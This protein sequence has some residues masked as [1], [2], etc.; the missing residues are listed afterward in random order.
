MSEKSPFNGGKENN[1]IEDLELWKQK[2]YYQRLG[3]SSGATD[4]EIKKAFRK[5]SI[6][7]HPDR[8]G[9][10]EALVKNYEEIYKLI[11]DARDKLTGK[12]VRQPARDSEGGDIYY[13]DFSHHNQNFDQKPEFRKE[14]YTTNFTKEIIEDLKSKP[15]EY[16]LKN[17]KESML[18]SSSLYEITPGE[19]LALFETLL[20]EGFV[21]TTMK[22]IST[23]SIDVA[24][25][26]ANEQILEMSQM[27]IDRQKLFQ[28]VSN[29]KN[30][31]GQQLNISS[32]ANKEE[33]I[34]YFVKSVNTFLDSKENSG[35]LFNYVTLLRDLNMTIE[36]LGKRGVTRPELLQAI[37][38]ILLGKFIDTVKG[39]FEYS[40]VN[41]G[42]REIGHVLTAFE[43]FG[44]SKEKLFTS[45]KD[46][47]NT[48][49]QNLSDYLQ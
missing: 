17:V 25:A 19:I 7:Y 45:V 20:V 23:L 30:V 10:D 37:E 27:G 48:R 42:V 3:I 29:L 18:A 9:R 41:Y 35:G 36:V 31:E 15:F 46:L 5:L 39:K 14:P 16:T 24:S 8:A 13:A 38:G 26:T 11:S 47:K 22:N 6:K 28:L 40:D 1:Q 43:E 32:E 49:G 4:E 44:I 33:T 21:T 34:K 2:S 12:V